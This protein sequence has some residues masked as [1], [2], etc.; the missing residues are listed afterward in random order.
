MTRAASRRRK[1]LGTCRGRLWS[2]SGVASSRH[3]TAALCGR[4]STGSGC[5]RPA[6][7]KSHRTSHFASSRL[8]CGVT[9][10]AIVETLSC[11]H[12]GEPSLDATRA[13]REER[14]STEPIIYRCQTIVLAQI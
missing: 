5:H 3:M 2:V 4:Q 8:L 11:A 7:F 6:A 1:N 9:A 13:T 10:R 12:D 14:V